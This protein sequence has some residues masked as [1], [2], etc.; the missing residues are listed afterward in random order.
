MKL[1]PFGLSLPIFLGRYMFQARL[2][3]S[4]KWSFPHRNCVTLRISYKQRKTPT[5]NY[6][7]HHR[8]GMFPSMKCF[9]L[10]YHM[11]PTPYSFLPSPLV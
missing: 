9:H 5:P 7:T 3:N 2:Q 6:S 4:L 8:T 1:S 10:S 11:P